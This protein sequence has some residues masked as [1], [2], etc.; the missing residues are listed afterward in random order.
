M[1]DPKSLLLNNSLLCE[2]GIVLLAERCPNSEIPHSATGK[3]ERKEVEEEEEGEERR[4]GC[5]FAFIRSVAL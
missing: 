2:K 5:C 4:G 1:I 3:R